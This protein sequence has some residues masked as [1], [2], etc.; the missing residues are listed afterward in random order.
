MNA[1]L[2]PSTFWIAGRAEPGASMAKPTN[3]LVYSRTVVTC[4]PGT[5]PS[6]AE[7][8]RAFTASRVACVEPPAVPPS[9]WTM[10]VVGVSSAASCT[11]EASG[12]VT[13]PASAWR[14]DSSAS[15]TRVPDC[16][17]FDEA[18]VGLAGRTPPGC[19]LAA[20]AGTLTPV[21]A[22][23]AASASAGVE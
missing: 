18:W 9:S 17:S 15:S 11:D 22:R 13:P 14:M 23:A 8:M 3:A 19:G 6:T 2:T 21:R 1:V 4:A 5:T 10:I 12:R 20:S 7:V 16:A